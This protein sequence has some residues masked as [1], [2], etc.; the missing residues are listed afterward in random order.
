MKYSIFLM[1]L[2]NSIAFSVMSLHASHNDYAKMM[3]DLY[4]GDILPRALFNFT[5]IDTSGCYRLVSDV[6]NQITI[7]ASNVILD[8]N[9]NTVG[10]IIINDG[11]TNI[12]V[13][14]GTVNGNIPTK[15]VA[16]DDA[17]EDGIF[18][19]GG[20]NVIL[21]GIVVKNFVHGI[22]FDQVTNGIISNCEMT[23]NTTGLQFDTSQ[24]IVVENCKAHA[25]V[26]AGYSLLTSTS[27]SFV[28][29]KTR[30][31]GE[32]NT[33]LSGDTSN[34][35]GFVTS[36]GSYNVFEQ[37]VANLTQSLTVT[38]PESI[39]AG[40]GLRGTEHC[41]TIIGC[42]AKNATTSSIGLTIPYG[43]WLEARFEGLTTVTSTNQVTSADSTNSIAWSPDGQYLAAGQNTTG[44][45]AQ[46]VLYRFDRTLGE[47]VPVT[48][49]SIGNSG[50]NGS[51]FGISSV[52]WSPDGE[53]LA[54]GGF[55]LS[56]P[57]TQALYIYKFDGSTETFT[58]I[59]AL[60]P[61]GVGDID[62]VSMAS[63]SPDG[64][65]LAVGV[66][67]TFSATGPVLFVYRFDK[68]AQTLTLVASA[69]DAAAGDEVNTLHWSPDGKYVAIGGRL[70]TGVPLVIYSFNESTELLTEVDSASPDG[71]TGPIAIV[72]SVAWSPDGQFLAVGVD[73]SSQVL[74][75]Q[76]FIYTFSR[77]TQTLTQVEAIR[78]SAISDTNVVITL[79]WSPDSN[80]LAIGGVMDSDNDVFLYKFNHA[81]LK[82]TEVDSVNPGDGLA[83]SINSVRW[84]PDGGYLG[85]SG[86]INRLT[87]ETIDN[88]YIYTALVFPMNNVVM[89]NT[90]SRNS[91]NRNPGG[92][93]IS[94]SSMANLIVGNVAFENPINPTI[95]S[96]NYQFVTNVFNSLFNGALHNIQLKNKTSLPMLYGNESV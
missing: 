12:I 49:I 85:V 7:T 22:H 78:P 76:L 77:T 46:M 20:T 38:A 92:I 57:T 86:R 71:I 69:K 24:N 36:N 30:A 26:Q 59:I 17:S 94:G 88:I 4:G 48:I 19:S 80:Y 90:A 70:A 51:G 31:T 32:G 28:E 56:A 41:S 64:K 53:Y 11:L 18:V 27:C 60:T 54:I 61:S 68:V 23:C 29:C 1:L 74:A 95:V 40:F 83:N 58:E 75:H 82:L 25:N 39:V 62:I 67:I 55:N 47:L 5:T 16:V 21:N 73:D 45:P 43:I 50:N 66:A 14:N 10:G 8:M 6:N 33:S 34:I 44:L 81:T 52:A 13:N 2:I 3:R 93:G 84:S 9:G 15:N 87:D 96:S 65:Y 42:E 37:C 63:W 35:F 89:N 72:D 91:G 79:S